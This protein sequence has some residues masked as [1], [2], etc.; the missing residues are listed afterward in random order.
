MIIG[1][2]GTHGTGKSTVLQGLKNAGVPVSEIQISRTAQSILGWDKLSRAEESEE[3]MWKLQDAIISIM[4]DRD[5]AIL[6][7]QI[8]T[9]VERTPADV[10]AYTTI[11]CDRLGINP[12]THAKAVLYKQ[13]C[14]ELAKQYEKFIIIPAAA[15]ITFVAEANRADAKSRE[16]VAKI[17]TTFLAHSRFN[18]R[19]I[20]SV[21]P[22]ARVNEALLF[23]KGL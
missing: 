2:C 16:D 15:D 21:L 3:N 20:A 5:S 13:K 18:Y 7:S 8:Q 10:W 14:I 23:I 9:V 12:N 17:I 1:I 19:T 6:K 22:D 4:E 11:W